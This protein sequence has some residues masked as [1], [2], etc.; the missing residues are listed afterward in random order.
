ME[1]IKTLIIRYNISLARNNVLLGLLSPLHQRAVI[2]PKEGRVAEKTEGM[3]LRTPVQE[4][5]RNRT[6]S[7][8]RPPLRTG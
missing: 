3:R 4:D 2:Q 7:S 5:I 8:L 1:I 6:S